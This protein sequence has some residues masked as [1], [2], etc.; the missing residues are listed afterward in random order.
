[1]LLLCFVLVLVFPGREI[2]VRYR[3]KRKV[4]RFS[5]KCLK[6]KQLGELVVIRS[7]LV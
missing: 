7:F 6:R 4:H 5:K 1:M 3:R 2:A